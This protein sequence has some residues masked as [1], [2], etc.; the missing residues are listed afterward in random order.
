MA[1][2]GIPATDGILGADGKTSLANFG[3]LAKDGMKN[4]DEVV[5]QIMQEKIK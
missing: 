1:G 5:L 2:V 3:F 4:V